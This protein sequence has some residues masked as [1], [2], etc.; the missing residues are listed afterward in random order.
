MADER[1]VVAIA[2]ASNYRKHGTTF[3]G[4]SFVTCVCPKAACGGVDSDDE[5][6]DCPEHRRT[7]AQM[8]HWAAECPGLP[9]LEE[10]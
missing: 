8:W 3:L 2:R 5:R 1:D 4:G 6:S 9:G 7:P 10:T